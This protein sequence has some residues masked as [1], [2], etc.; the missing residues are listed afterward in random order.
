MN[1][2]AS[3]V[4]SAALTFTGAVG[5]SA[6]LLA[7]SVAE[8]QQ[9]VS[10]KVG[11]PLKAAQEAVQKKNWNGALAKIKEAQAVTPRTPYDD[12]MINELLWYVYL[13]QGRNA[14]AARL[15]EQ[16]IAS[17]QMPANQKVSRTKTLAQ[18]YFRSGNYGKAIQ[19]ANQYLKSAPGDQEM[20]LMVA[21]GYFQQKDYKNAVAMAERM[22]KGQ[23]KPSEDLLQLMQRSYYELKDADGTARTLELLLKYY[24]S[25]DT[26][27]RLLGGII[28]QT[29]HDHELIALYRLS[30]DVGALRKPNQYIDM[31]QALVVGGFAIEGQ[32]VL[33]KGIASGAFT[34]EDQAR[35]QRTLDTAKRRADE[36]RKTLAGADK[37]LAAAKTGDAAYEVG[38]LYFSA[39]DYAKA[40]V[41]MQKAVS[42]PGL[43]DVD[44]ANAELGMALARQ[45]KKA[46]AAKAF[47][48]IKDPKYAEIG[49]LWKLRLR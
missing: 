41:A 28:E 42:L 26:W 33:E 9:K 48:A 40:A 14:D 25:P 7:P 31:T 43:A 47:D 23:A 4:L 24:P 10:A 13:Q 36:Q 19:T 39:G 8:A 45:D 27:G 2:K 37:A 30:E 16:Q 6:A 35:A 46:E 15:L 38:K 32:R 17:G 22:A 3:W 1:T 44:D 29:N 49:K 5:V 20:Q 21:Q 12:Y 34:A 11:V 18:L